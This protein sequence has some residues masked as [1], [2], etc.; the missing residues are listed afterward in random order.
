MKK[1]IGLFKPACI[2]TLLFA[3]V[4]GLALP[5]FW[6]NNPM[7]ELGTLSLLCE[8]RKMWFWLWGVLTSGGLFLNTQYMYKKFNEKTDFLIYSVFLAF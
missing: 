6:G 7:S 3:F 4:Y 5:F 1:S 8:N 2:A